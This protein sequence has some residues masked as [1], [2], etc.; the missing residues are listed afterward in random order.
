MQE[1]AG[2][3]AGANTSTEPALCV[4]RL[5]LLPASAAAE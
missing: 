1:A 3:P 5:A 4:R 2:L